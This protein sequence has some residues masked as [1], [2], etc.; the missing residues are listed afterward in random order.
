MLNSRPPPFLAQD[1]Y[2]G[3]ILHDSVSIKAEVLQLVRLGTRFIVQ[4][5]K[6]PYAVLGEGYQ[7][8]WNGVQPVV[9]VTEG[10]ALP[11]EGDA[12]VVLVGQHRGVAYE[13]AVERP[14]VEMVTEGMPVP[15]ALLRLQRRA[16]FRV[17]PIGALSAVL[18]LDCLPGA[19]LR[20]LDLSLNGL[21]FCVTA[22]QC[23]RLAKVAQNQGSISGRLTL[24]RKGPLYERIGVAV[25]V[26]NLTKLG[27]QQSTIRL[28]CGMAPSPAAGGFDRVLNA[29]VL[30]AQREA[31]RARL[32][33]E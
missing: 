13:I 21:S 3:F 5:L 23:L 11:V 27:E 17:T 1:E 22:E 33:D 9:R 20:V 25:R 24:V 8:R 10:A 30:E 28:G 6:P 15:S 12:P 18:A 7:L 14:F 32:T 4:E 26:R 29:F 31:V 19:A 2:S 16:F